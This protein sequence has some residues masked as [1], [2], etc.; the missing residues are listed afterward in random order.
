[1]VLI[2]WGG[3][4]QQNRWYIGPLITLA[5]LLL[6]LL[7]SGL[8]GL[9]LSL[10]RLL[11]GFG[12]GAT[13]V[14]DPHTQTWRRQ[15]SGTPSS[16]GSGDG[17]GSSTGAGA[18]AAAG[19]SGGAALVSAVL[20]SLTTMVVTAA[21][22]VVLLKLFF[23]ARRQGLGPTLRRLLLEGFFGGWDEQGGGRTGQQAQRGP[24]RSKSERLERVAH[25]MQSLPVEV[26]RSREELERLSVAD[27]K[28][29][30]EKR[31]LECRECLEKPELVAALSEGASSGGSTAASCIIC[32]EDYA[33]D[34][35][36]RLVPPPPAMPVHM[37]PS[38]ALHLTTMP[39]AA[40]SHQEAPAQHDSSGADHPSAA[41]RER[42]AAQFHSQ[43]M[44]VAC[45]FL[46]WLESQPLMAASPEACNGWAAANHVP[47]ATLQS[48][49]MWLV[50]QHRLRCTKMSSPM[51][52]PACLPLGG[53]LHVRCFGC[54][55]FITAAGYQEHTKH[56]PQ[57]AAVFGVLLP[58]ADGYPRPRR[59]PG[60]CRKGLCQH[61]RPARQG[62]AALGKPSSPADNQSNEAA[63]AQLDGPAPQQ[64]GSSWLSGRNIALGGSVATVVLL[65][66]FRKEIAPLVKWLVIQT[67]SWTDKSVIGEWSTES[68]ATC[69]AV[70]LTLWWTFAERMKLD[71]LEAAIES[72]EA[73]ME[74]RVAALEQQ[75]AAREA[76]LQARIAALEGR[77][78]GGQAA[79]AA[80]AAEAA[81]QGAQQGVQRGQ[82]AGL[83][84]PLGSEHLEERA[85][86]QSTCGSRAAP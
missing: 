73:A 46:S 64:P 40:S 80:A 8:L 59:L 48:A 9:P 29:L 35:V 36:L 58:G 60:A 55:R 62:K 13:W 26:Y 21:I 30:L 6:P 44:N 67:S 12:G 72:R 2:F 43:R 37:P 52:V 78:A 42:A 76:A 16:S 54:G 45:R 83:Q 79:A 51:G 66:V 41:A 27:L 57:A 23:A 19:G 74:A 81:Q 22:V 28:R 69:I 24:T 85:M 65:T 86:V 53:V 31:G 5:P 39:A 32:C 14:Y 15:G 10:L 49:Q 38:Q 3:F 75:Q 61:K 17:G 77:L 71:S 84:A 33:S 70:A 25:L 1:M 63:A 20:Q 68:I 82:Q 11:F 34:D 56:C 47:N 4:G 50:Q 7:G 18:A